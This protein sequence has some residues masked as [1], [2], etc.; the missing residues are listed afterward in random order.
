MTLEELFYALGEALHDGVNPLSKVKLFD[1]ES[2]IDVDLKSVVANVG[3]G[4]VSVT[5]SSNSLEPSQPHPGEK[6]L[7]G[8]QLSWATIK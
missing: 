4:E 6:I 8:E 7:W 1:D 3:S 5:L 2:L